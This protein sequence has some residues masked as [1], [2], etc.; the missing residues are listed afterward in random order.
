V[1]AF[2]PAFATVSLIFAFAA[3]VA[4]LAAKAFLP[5]LANAALKRRTT[6][7]LSSYWQSRVL[8]PKSAHIFGLSQDVPLHRGV[9]FLARRSGRETELCIERI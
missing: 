5:L 4:D 1:R 2:R 9:K 3:G 8:A 6:R 7:T